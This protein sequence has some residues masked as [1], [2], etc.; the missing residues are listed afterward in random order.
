M[1]P[2]NLLACP[3]EAPAVAPRAGWEPVTQGVWKV[4]GFHAREFSLN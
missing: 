4:A 2:E 3:R 1:V